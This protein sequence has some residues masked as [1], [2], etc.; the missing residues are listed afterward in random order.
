MPTIEIVSVPIDG[1]DPE[2][3]GDVDLLG[4]LTTTIEMNATTGQS[5][6]PFS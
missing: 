3:M 2:L 1:L 6:E 5:V 4:A